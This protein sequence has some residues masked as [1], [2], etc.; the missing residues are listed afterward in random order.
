MLDGLFTRYEEEGR[1]LRG[2]EPRDLLLRVR[3]IC[4]Y[5]DLKLTLNQQ[6]LD[7]AWTGYFGTA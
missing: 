1:S 3:D 5:R 7:Q 4:R 2:C 6:L